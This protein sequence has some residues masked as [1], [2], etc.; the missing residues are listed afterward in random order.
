LRRFLP[1]GAFAAAAID[2]STATPSRL[3]F[4]FWGR[5]SFGL[6]F[7]GLGEIRLG[8]KDLWS[9]AKGELKKKSIFSS[10]V[11]FFFFCFFFYV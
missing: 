5:G 10:G 11:G 7:F 1:L 8:D 6:E 9:F 3:V 4:F 2:S